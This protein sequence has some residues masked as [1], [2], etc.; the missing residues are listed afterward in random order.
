MFYTF[1]FSHWCNRDMR[2]G[3]LNSFPNLPLQLVPTFQPWKSL[4]LTSVKL[5][6]SVFSG[7][8]SSLSP[9]LTPTHKHIFPHPY[10]Q[11]PVLKSSLFSNSHEFHP[12]LHPPI[13]SVT[14]IIKHLI[15]A[16]LVFSPQTLEWSL[17]PALQ[18]LFMGP[19]FPWDC[20]LLGAET[21][22]FIFMSPVAEGEGS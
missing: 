1:V 10:R 20:G 2:Y 7:Q 21:V 17:S 5:K 8:L 18:L 12:I 15:S 22:P 19:S 6:S 14:N 16:H 3:Q 11:D 9:T 13:S 4:F